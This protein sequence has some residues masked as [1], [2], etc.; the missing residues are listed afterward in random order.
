MAKTKTVKRLKDKHRDYFWLDS[1]G[2]LW[3]FNSLAEQ[4]LVVSWNHV[5]PGFEVPGGDF[6]PHKEYGPFTRVNR[7][8]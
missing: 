6:K 3:Y 7:W 2:D 5:E 1:D 8:P 4:W